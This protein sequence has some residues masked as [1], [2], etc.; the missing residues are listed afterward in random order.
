MMVRSAMM[1]I[2]T[3]MTGA[4]AVEMIV[5]TVLSK[6]L[7]LVTMV[8]PTQTPFPTDAECLAPNTN[9]VTKLLIPMKSATME[10]W[11]LPFALLPAHALSVVMESDKEMRNAMTEMITLTMLLMVVL[12][13]ALRTN[14]EH[15]SQTGKLI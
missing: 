10:Y 12:P 14:V 4:L 5:E 7:K 3:M 1:E 6:V 11:D 9:A 15:P 13:F 8:L 2:P